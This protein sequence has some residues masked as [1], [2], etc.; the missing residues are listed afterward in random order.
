MAKLPPMRVEVEG[1]P[2]VR[3]LG[4][5]AQ[6]ARSVADADPDL[7]VGSVKVY[8]ASGHAS[9][10][11]DAAKALLSKLE[12]PV[13]VI[14]T[15]NKF[16]VSADAGGDRIR[17]ML[18]PTLPISVEDALGLAAW[19]VAISGKKERFGEIYEAVCNT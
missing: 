2:I 19:I 4:E 14:D 1:L 5:A 18:P 15:T 10:L 12:P 11:G 6:L 8:N 16:L 17:I 3:L 13:P 9:W 7:T